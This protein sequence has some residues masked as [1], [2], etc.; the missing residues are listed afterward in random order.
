MLC[1]ITLF[2]LGLVNEAKATERLKL[3]IITSNSSK[4]YESVISAARKE[5]PENTRVTTIRLDRD[6]F[7]R[8]AIEEQDFVLSLGVLAAQTLNRHSLDMPM[9]FALLP[10]SSYESYRLGTKTSAIFL[11]QPISRQLNLLA[12]SMPER[13]SI[14]LL[15]S[16]P[17]D[18]RLVDIESM[19]ALMKLKVEKEVVSEP[20]YLIEKLQHI[21]MKS[22]VYLS[23]PDPKLINRFSVQQVL[24]RSYRSKI[25]VIGF[26]KAFVRAGATLAVYSTPDQIG[27]Q[28]GEEISKFLKNPKRYRP[29]SKYPK[30]FSVRVNRKVAESL[31]I[32]IPIESKLVRQLREHEK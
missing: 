28:A 14:G 12:I 4:S 24:L 10:K 15:S 32:A 23:L 27:T 1:F 29:T 21:L 7:Q 30:Y 18:S 2:S 3:L 31:R 25:P 22:D 17:T 20:K 8:E 11:D 26:S 13:K 9:L 16:D 6:N 19:A 5:L